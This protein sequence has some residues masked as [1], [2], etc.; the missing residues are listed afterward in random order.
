MVGGRIGVGCRVVNGGD[1]GVVFPAPAWSPFLNNRVMPNNAA[2]IMTRSIMV[3]FKGLLVASDID[4]LLLRIK[5]SWTMHKS[6]ELPV[7]Q[8]KQ[9]LST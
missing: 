1:A 2:R 3:F 4:E 5:A 9:G 8:V 7:M 6:H